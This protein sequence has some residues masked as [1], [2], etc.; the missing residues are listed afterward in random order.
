MGA[1]QITGITFKPDWIPTEQTRTRFKMKRN[2]DLPRVVH[3]GDPLH[4]LGAFRMK[5]SQSSA[6]SKEPVYAIHGTP[7]EAS[8]GQ[9]ASGGCIRM[10]QTEGLALAEKLHKEMKAGRSIAVVISA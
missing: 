7:D 6:S 4:M 10:K 8:I 5:L 9:R 2:I 3:F 1:G